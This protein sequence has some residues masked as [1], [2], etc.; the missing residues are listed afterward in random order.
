MSFGYKNGKLIKLL[1]IR[2]TLIANGRFKD[3]GGVDN[4]ISK[5][6]KSESSTITTP[7]TAFI[8]WETQE[9]YERCNNYLFQRTT[10]GLKNKQKQTFTVFGFEPRISDAPEPTNIIWENLEV[11]NR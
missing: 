6:L 10:N 9:G 11:T 5:I 1:Q 8:T 3:L 4:A 2:G 7:V